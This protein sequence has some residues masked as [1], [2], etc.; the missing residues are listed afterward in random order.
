MGL[1]TRPRGGSLA[2]AVPERR[3]PHLR[4]CGGF[5][6]SERKGGGEREVMG[7]KKW[8]DWDFNVGF[9]VENSIW[10]QRERESGVTGDVA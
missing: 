10:V 4:R 7:V 2:A 6:Q 9:F 5:F 8:K 3:L 1:D